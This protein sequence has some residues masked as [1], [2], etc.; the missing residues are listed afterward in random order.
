MEFRSPLERGRER[1]NWKRQEG[2]CGRERHERC[3]V[4]NIL[5]F[6]RLLI[7][8]LGFRNPLVGHMMHEGGVTA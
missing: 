7:P 2:L 6:T 8:K 5:T 4:I 1:E 3:A